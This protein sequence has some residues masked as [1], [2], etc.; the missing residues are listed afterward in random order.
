MTRETSTRMSRTA[1][2]RMSL[3][4]FV[5]LSLPAA[6]AQPDW[7]GRSDPPA[8]VARVTDVIGDAWLFDDENKEWTRLMRNQTIAEGDRL[9]TDD[10]ARVALRAGS[11]ALW[12]DEG[13]DLVLDRFDE[14][15][16]RL[17]L[18]RGDMV[19]Q[20]RSREAARD[21]LVQTREG[22]LQPESDGLYR[23]EQLDRGTLA[24][25]WSGRLRFDPSSSGLS[26]WV[27]QGEQV[28]FWV[29]D[30]SPR[31][32]RMGLRSDAFGDWA[33][34]QSR[35]GEFRGSSQRYVSPEMTGAEDLDRYGAWER[36]PDYGAVWFPS[37]VA[38]DWVPYRYGH[39]VWTRFWGWSW[40]D[41]SPWGFAPFHY[42]RW[43]QWRG[44]WCWAPGTFVARPVYAPAL[45]AFVG[46]PSVSFGI[47]FNFGQRRPPP[48]SGAWVPLAPHET[49]VPVYRHSDTYL[50]RLNGNRD[51]RPVQ[52]PRNAQVVGAVSRPI[53]DRP[54]PAAR[55]GTDMQWRGPNRGERDR[56]NAWGRERGNNGWQNPQ[57]A[58]RPQPAMQQPAVQAQQ[59]QP[60]QQV[61][62]DERG[63]DQRPWQRSN[64]R[65]EQPQAQQPPQLQTV[66][67]FQPANPRPEQRFGGADRREREDRDDI[68][69]QD[70]RGNWGRGPERQEQQPQVQQQPQPQVQQQQQ[71]FQPPL[72]HPQPQFQPQPQPQFQ[73]QPQP[74][75][76]PQQQRDDHKDRGDPG[77]DR[78]RKEPEQQQQR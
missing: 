67:Q 11:T 36:T 25:A 22:Q 61:P 42:G 70:R 68:D 13:S 76:Q 30:G 26:T 7:Q 18:D 47:S 41:D 31:A 4:L 15:V 46:G 27:E 19:V 6:H 60:P 9:R 34:G 59:A 37:M 57:Q 43:V 40:V 1:W 73:P 2:L 77:R 28:E 78:K 21:L 48:P 74:Q 64:D 3:A 62:R 58:Q 12:L 51:L 38:V 75:A 32:E 29:V 16:V 66:P 10:R 33:L 52:Q 53:A 24:R 69:R 20:L 5:G 56:D 39:W 23:V 55:P 49:Y 8:R 71:V 44:R 72:Q 45:V 54:V 17:Q 65:R 50:Y 35:E 14:G 63:Q